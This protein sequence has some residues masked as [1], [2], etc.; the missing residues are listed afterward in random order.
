MAAPLALSA[1][2]DRTAVPP[3]ERT[4]AYLS[5]DVR[6]KD[7]E[8]LPDRPAFAVVFLIDTSAS[9]KGPPLENVVSSVDRLISMLSPRDRF[10]VVSFATEAT[11]V[12]SLV[13]A[14]KETVE[15]ARHRL[16]DLVAHGQTNMEAGLKLATAMLGPKIADV[17]E[18]IFLLSDGVPNIGKCTPMTIAELVQPWRERMTLWSLGYGPHHQ[19]DILVATSDVG[20]GRY[21]FIPQPEMCEFI[22][23]KALGAQG[24]VVGDAVELRL[25]P[26]EGVE[27]KRVLGKYE[28][29]YGSGGLVLRLPDV[30]VQSRRRIAFELAVGPWP[31]RV[32]TP[33]IDA[34]L[35]ARVAGTTERHVERAMV[36]VD[37][38]NAR[39]QIV[40]EAREGILLARCDEI[41]R[42]ARA[43][44]D[45]GKFDEAAK[46]VN[47]ALAGVQREPW[48]DPARH[49]E[50]A[51]AC[52]LLR[53]E[54]EVLTMQPTVET[55]RYFRRS[56]MAIELSGES[57]S[58]SDHRMEN[59][60]GQQLVHAVA[61]EY[62]IARLEQL[63]GSGKVYDLR[64]EQSIGRGRNCDIVIDSPG[65]SRAHA[66]IV[67]QGGAFH[68]MDLGSAS[69]TMRN[70]V[71][72]HSARLHTQD[73]LSFGPVP[74]QYTERAID[75]D[76]R[77]CAI[78]GN[79]DVYVLE[80]DRLFVMG[81]SRACSLVVNE[82]GISPRH[83]WVEHTDGKWWLGAYDSSAGVRRRGQPVT[84]A[85]IRH[86]DVFQ[87]GLT[88]VRFELR[89]PKPSD[90]EPAS[91]TPA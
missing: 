46:M 23:A 91:T 54:C 77:M 24:D 2:L 3:L 21:Q 70:G 42:E 84:K 52:D 5:V 34:I 29:R 11:E 13:P 43:L 22:F 33:V 9:M 78:A 10:A 88:L 28:Q 4:A 1:S 66:Q 37:V 89:K 6:A 58:A 75:V 87:L 81:R 35:S 27:I 45:Q 30:F 50:L 53:D 36:A 63:D 39:P 14:S 72:I 32:Q 64:A 86:G 20:G 17:R 8:S 18:Q 62:P 16:G 76:D 38:T 19:E 48:Y 26:Q 90:Q 7:P 85:E 73:Q 56:Q 15:R 61:G 40:E 83:A 80:K 82:M 12:V 25:V 60:Y 44:A 59:L 68:V 79:G 69:G 55:Y 65:V 71:K 41:R 49:H 31:L 67:A 47:A 74:F 51:D 57:F